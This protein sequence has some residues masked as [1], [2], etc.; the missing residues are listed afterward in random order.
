MV[1]V[2]FVIVIVNCVAITFFVAIIVNCVALTDFVAIIVNCVALT[3]FVAIIENCVALTVFVA[4]IVNCVAPTVFVAIIVNCVAPTVFVAIIV[5]YV[6][7]TVN[8]VTWLCKSSCSVLCMN[9][10]CHFA[11][12]FTGQHWSAFCR[13]H[14]YIHCSPVEYLSKSPH[15]LAVSQGILHKVGKSRLKNI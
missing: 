4:I 11:E 3:D 9:S 8:F 7:K 5:N 10:N 6:T 15:K 14:I 13:Y 12:H 1:T 2:N